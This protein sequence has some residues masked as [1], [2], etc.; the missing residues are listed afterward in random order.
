MSAPHVTGVAALFLQNN[1][2]ATSQAVYDAITQASTKNIVTNS[3]TANNHLVYSLMEDSGNGDHGGGDNGNGDD[4]EPGDNDPSIDTFN[5]NAR[6]A[7]PWLRATV[8]WAVSDV[9]G[10]LETVMIEMLDGG[11]AVDSSTINVSGSSAS[12]ETEL[13]TRNT[14]GSL[15]LTVTD[16]N[17]NS[18]S[19]ERDI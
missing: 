14:A 19:Y 4:D 10:D 3:I 11:S 13:R 17:G 1:T 18:T 5:V 9:D 15:R 8:N 12:G 2:D 6:S 16:S 7:G